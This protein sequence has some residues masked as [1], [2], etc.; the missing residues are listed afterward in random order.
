MVQYIL[1]SLNWPWQKN[2]ENW[3][4]FSLFLWENQ[5]ICKPTSAVITI[6]Q[7][8]SNIFYCYTSSF[9]LQQW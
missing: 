2:K 7:M 5:S 4:K 8:Y 3:E 6:S 1:T 9:I